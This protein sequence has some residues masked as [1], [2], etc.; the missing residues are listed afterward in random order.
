MSEFHPVFEVNPD[1]IKDTLKREKME[2]LSLSVARLKR[3]MTKEE[4]HLK[5]ET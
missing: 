3:A 1:K 4:E 5:D 2:S